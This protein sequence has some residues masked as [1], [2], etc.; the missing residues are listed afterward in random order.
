MLRLF[1]LVLSLLICSKSYAENW[2]CFD[3]TSKQIKSTLHGDG[4]NLGIC[5]LNNSNIRPDC[6]LATEEEY[7][8][9]KQSY[10]K[11]DPSIISGNRI[12]DMT[13]QEKDAFTQSQ[14]TVQ[15][16]TQSNSIDNLNVSVSDIFISFIKVYNSK[17]P[18]GQ[19]ITKQEIINQL[20]VDKGL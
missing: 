13:Q 20:K 11:Y 1:I 9:A 14:I 16:Q 6:I 8:A 4:M 5:G 12:V 10:K 19:K 18:V 17:M 3:S 7:Q 15:N 2:V